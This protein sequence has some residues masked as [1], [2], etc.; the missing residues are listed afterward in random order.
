NPTPVRERTVRRMDY[1]PRSGRR[2]VTARRRWLIESKP[3]QYSSTITVSSRT[4]TSSFQESNR[5][6]SVG[7]RAR[8]LST[9][10]RIRMASQNKRPLPRERG[11]E[12]LFKGRGN[13]HKPADVPYKVVTLTSWE[14]YLSIISDSPYQ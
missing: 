1:A 13:G 10:T 3:A 9:T 14:E 8:Q 11:G 12:R 6:G 4:C 7:N 5:A 2:I